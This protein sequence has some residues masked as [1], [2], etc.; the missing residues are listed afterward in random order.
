MDVEQLGARL[1]YE[2]LGVMAREI[3][4]LGRH[5]V[6]PGDMWFE[7]R[8]VESPRSDLLKLTFAV[9]PVDGAPEA[10]LA[11]LVLENPRKLTITSDDLTI[12]T[13]DYVRFEETCF[14]VAHGQV[15][16]LQRGRAVA[17]FD[18]AGA[19]ALRLACEHRP[20]G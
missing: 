8:R 18:A 20:P 12:A 15:H 5:V 16:E 6:R 17:T 1:Q 13:A 2:R 10:S 7:L 3:C 11:A 19:P 9:N 14:T 4:V